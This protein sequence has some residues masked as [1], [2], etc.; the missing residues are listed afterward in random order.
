MCSGKVT[1]SQCSV[2]LPLSPPASRYPLRKC[3]K[4]PGQYGT[5]CRH[6]DFL[7]VAVQSL[8]R[9]QFFATPWLEIHQASLSFMISLSLLKLMSVESV[10][11]SYHLILC[12]PF[13]LLP[14]IFPSIRGFS[15]ESADELGWVERG[16]GGTQS[17]SAWALE[18]DQPPDLLPS[19]TGGPPGKVGLT[20]SNTSP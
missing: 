15:S 20:A 13:L 17:L 6:T 16:S 8:S 10:M 18:P 14:S 9:V 2:P 19:W 4:E 7:A 3:R 5:P 1:S 11:Q 12:H